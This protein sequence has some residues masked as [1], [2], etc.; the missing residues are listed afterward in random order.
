MKR[1]RNIWKI[2]YNEHDIESQ[3]KASVKVSESQIK[4]QLFLYWFFAKSYSQLI[5]VLKTP[6]LRQ[7]RY[8]GHSTTKWI[9]FC[10]FLTPTPLSG[11]FLYP[12]HGQ[13]RHFLTPSP[14][15]L[16]HVLIE[17]PLT[18]LGFVT[19][20]TVSVIKVIPA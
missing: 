17:C 7:Q 4:T 9:K 14:P 20:C 18:L 10:H 3:I 11:P 13:N 8:R 6:P 12:E 5:L 19:W 15:H 2:F 1:N 16:V